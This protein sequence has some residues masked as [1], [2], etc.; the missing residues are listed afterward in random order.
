M[1]QLLKKTWLLFYTIAFGGLLILAM[2]LFSKQAEL[3]H[4]IKAEQRYVTKLFDSHVSSAFSQ[5]ES[6][7]ELISY[8]SI[9]HQNLNQEI[10]SNVLSKSSLLIGFALFTTDGN[11]Q[12]VSGNLQTA[13][14]SN[15]LTNEETK[16]SFKQTLSQDEMTIGRPYYFNG[17]RKWIIPIRKRIVNNQ[18]ELIG[19]IA[20][21]IE[22][23]TL[24]KQWND[25]STGKRI[26]QA[27]LDH[28]FYRILQ[29]NL[30]VNKYRQVFGLPVPE[31]Y[32]T[33]V[34]AQIE[35]Q[36]LSLN[37]IRKSGDVVQLK[38]QFS[39]MS[40]VNLLYNKDLNIWFTLIE[41]NNSLQKILLQHLTIYGALYL[42]VIV[43]IFFLF[44]WVSRIERHKIAE[45]TYRAEHDLLTG[46][47]NRSI[48][49]NRESKYHR[50][51]QPFSLLYIDL[52]HFKSINDSY[53][54]S[55]GDLILIEV[56]KRISKALNKIDD[57]AI[58]VSADE[59]I[60]LI[61]CT[62]KEKLKQYCQNLL[63]EINLPYIVNNTDFKISAS[64]GIAQSPLNATSIETL[65]SYAN[66][67]MLIAKKSKN[68]YVFF[69]KR[70]HLQ[71][72]KKIEIEQALQNALVKNEITL[73]YQPQLNAQHEL[74]GVEALVRWNNEKLG[75]IS[76]EIFIPIAEKTGLMPA[77]GAYIMNKAMADIST[78]QYKMKKSFKLSI[79]VS[80]RQF[81]QL[82]FFEALCDCLNCYKS[83]YMDITIEI[84]ESLFI[85]NVQ[86]LRPIFKKMKEQNVSLS[87][88]DF[89]TGYSS[90]S[91]L[92]NVPIDE[93]K[94]DKSF[95]DFITDNKNDRA[96]VESI[97]TMGKNL[98]MTVLAEGV[99]TE[100]QVT[101]L[102]NKGCDLYQGYYF[103]KP[104]TLDALEVFIGNPR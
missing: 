86:R 32:I 69:S 67:S 93:L 49:A 26:M 61:D 45:L 35:Q 50:K 5:F 75:I 96:M 91:M 65:I 41:S 77:I 98:G 36:G 104:L 90:L 19:V 102:K 29:S 80:A 72:I 22:L 30:A 59:F 37:D 8:E 2:S 95:I 6:M 10:I 64:I 15:L 97:I 81:V 73:V 58:R 83:P 40:N 89:G 56:S 87:L 101:I 100:K 38:V 18:G 79:N 9:A 3:E 76:P 99:E 23:Q 51:N 11:V 27:T 43:I 53:G 103:S 16:Q 39:E 7:L 42:F 20:S 34:K 71:L 28:S 54:Y 78:L 60:L 31:K 12:S 66:N 62:D 21:A 46:L 84:T 70:I 48:L 17:V 55:Y 82:N 94:I 85:E 13:H 74:Y 25:I 4:D 57:T 68:C 24:A 52:D 14:F 92:K 33:A 88:D 1:N 44:K 63:A 47:Y